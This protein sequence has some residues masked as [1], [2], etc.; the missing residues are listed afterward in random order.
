MDKDLQEFYEARFD[1]MATKGWKDL[2]ED[3][4]KM[5]ITY[6]NLFEVSTEAELNF[7]KGQ[8]DILLWLLSLKET[9]EQ[10]WMEL[11]EDA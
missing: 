4:D 11:Q 3:V 1:M 10:A 2:M 6:N 7:K 9:S 5:S 8:I